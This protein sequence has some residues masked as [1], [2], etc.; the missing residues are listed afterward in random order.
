MTTTG[1][2]SAPHR[3]TGESDKGSRNGYLCVC[4]GKM[5]G[6]CGEKNGIKCGQTREGSP[7]LCTSTYDV[8]MNVLSV[9][10]WKGKFSM[11]L[12]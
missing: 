3:Q 9:G 10:K 12:K 2:A 5:G 6:A 11:T 4:I 1:E 8:Q 7:G